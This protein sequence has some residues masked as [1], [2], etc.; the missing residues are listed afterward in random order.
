MDIDPVFRHQMEEKVQGP[1]K[2]WNIHL[3]IF[4][5]FRHVFSL[6]HTIDFMK[7]HTHPSCFIVT[8]MGMEG[9]RIPKVHKRGALSVCWHLP[10]ERI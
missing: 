9:N 7:G 10:L 5:R 4:C 8:H 6:P 1:F 2:K 3:V